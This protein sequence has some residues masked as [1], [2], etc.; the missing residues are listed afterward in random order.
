MLKKWPLENILSIIIKKAFE[1]VEIYSNN[2]F[3]RMQT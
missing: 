3:Y 2:V 1:I